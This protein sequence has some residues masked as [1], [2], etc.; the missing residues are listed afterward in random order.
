MDAIWAAPG[1]HFGPII[2]LVMRH[3]RPRP[4]KAGAHATSRLKKEERA[5]NLISCINALTPAAVHKHANLRIKSDPQLCETTTTHS[6]FASVI[7]HPTPLEHE[8]S[9]DIT[10]T[11]F[12][13]QCAFGG[14]IGVR[15]TPLHRSDE[16]R[17]HKPA[18]RQWP[19]RVLR[20]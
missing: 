1:P 2:W 16:M 18:T 11:A 14:Q 10:D 3:T 12:Q 7:C 13:C 19:P 8:F 5:L 20:K 15:R 17:V 4:L 9:R 6:E